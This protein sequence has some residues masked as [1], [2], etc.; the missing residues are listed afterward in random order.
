LLAL[1]D[2]RLAAAEQQALVELGAALGFGPTEV[3]MVVHKVSLRL[4]DALAAVAH[5]G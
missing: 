3:Q 2:R 1:A 4:E 5:S